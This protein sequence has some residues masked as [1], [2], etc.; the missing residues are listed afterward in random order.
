MRQQLEEYRLHCE[1]H[2]LESRRYDVHEMPD[3]DNIEDLESL[4]YL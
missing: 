3:L 2:G 1:E 4:G